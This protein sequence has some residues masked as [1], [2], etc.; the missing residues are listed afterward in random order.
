MADT[1]SQAKKKKQ[2]VWLVYLSLLIAG[3]IL[4]ADAFDIAHLNLWTGK[5]G[6]GLVWTALALFAGGGRPAG[7]AAVAIVWLAVLAT[8]LV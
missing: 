5:L 7:I 4:L 8:F 6:I 3:A 1:K 2:P